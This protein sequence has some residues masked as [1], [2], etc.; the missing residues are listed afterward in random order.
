MKDLGPPQVLYEG[1][2]VRLMRIGHWEFAQRQGRDHAVIILAMTE[3]REVIFVEQF[4]VPVGASVIEYPAGLVGD[5]SH[6][7]GESLETAA[8][9]ELEEETGYAAARVE[10]LISGPPSPGLASEHITWFRARELRK[11]GAGGGDSTE[12]ITVHRVPLAEAERWLEQR[13]AEG[14]LVDPKIYAGL[15]FLVR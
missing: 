2:Y 10:K 13:Q 12:N 6:H 15:Y 11:T 5:L 4:R 9:R 3:Q 8:L 14:S 1:R 7:A